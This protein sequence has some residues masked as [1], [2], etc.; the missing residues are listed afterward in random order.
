MARRLLALARATGLLVL[1]EY[2]DDQYIRY[3]LDRSLAGAVRLNIDGR[4]DVLEMFAAYGQAAA[5]RE[6]TIIALVEMNK[7]AAGVRSLI[8]GT[9]KAGSEGPG[10]PSD[11]ELLEWVLDASIVWSVDNT[12]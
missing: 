2:P 1:R 5:A 7:I 12:K 9:R 11:A 4:G 8:D 10:L 6:S 3:A